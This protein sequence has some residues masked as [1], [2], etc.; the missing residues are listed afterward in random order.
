[1]GF[2][3]MVLMLMNS[4]AAG[5]TD[6]FLNHIL[7]FMTGHM[8]VAVSER[9]TFKGP[10]I[11]DRDRFIA[12]VTNHVPR[13][14]EIREN[15]SIFSRVIGNGK[16]ENLLLTGLKQSAM[17][18]GGVFQVAEGSLADFSKPGAAV[19]Y[20]EKANLLKVKVGDS[21]NCKFQQVQGPFQT[22]SLKVVAILRNQSFFMDMAVYVDEAA[23]KE[24]L[25]YRPQETRGLHV[26]LDRP[27]ESEKDA[28]RIHKLLT[29]APAVLEGIF[30]FLD[31]QQEFP[32][33]PVKE[34]S[35]PGLIHQIRWVSGDPST[36]LGSNSLFV[37]DVLAKELHLT[38]G[39]SLTFRYQ[40]KFDGPRF[41]P[42]LVRGIYDPLRE[43]PERSALFGEEVFQKNYPVAIPVER[44][45]PLDFDKPEHPLYSSFI[46]EWTLLPRTKTQEDLQAKLARQAAQPWK[47]H[48][49][50][51]RTMNETGSQIVK[52]ESVL[53]RITL[54]A[55]FLMFFIILIGVVNSLRMSIRERTR[56]IG[57]VRAMG[58]QAGDIRALF[59]LE[60]V[61]LAFFASLAGFLM[62]LGVMGLTHF[63]VS[64]SNTP[65]SIFL[66]N[67][68]LHF[69]LKP[70][71]LFL[72]LVL[73]LAIT[74]VTAW[75]P[76]NRASK[77]GPAEALRHA[78]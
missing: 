40:S 5:L 74:A 33:L 36:L 70:L 14:K 72:Y 46:P 58:M 35:L 64:H 23:L 3:M 28:D 42:F 32:L 20:E 25:G 43:L 13:I 67:G 55:V 54:Y 61:F 24:L 69:V 66:L 44:K 21:L 76:A 1:M 73:I 18:N 15:V 65:L 22:A 27:G 39:Q 52:M 17:S 8:E 26:I 51:V 77:L 59:I 37:S 71:S 2:G 60:T 48:M 9:S 41:I 34:A 29:P 47:G 12:I 45:I 68:R 75:F 11:R 62:A 6:I 10:I 4:F 53:N 57:T 78:E 56:E 16:G 30:Y 49:V 31:M 19:L 63:A 7:V 38:V 50:D